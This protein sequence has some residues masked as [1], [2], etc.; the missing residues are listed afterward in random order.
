M[1]CGGCEGIEGVNRVPGT[2]F[3][4]SIFASIALTCFLW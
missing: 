1:K 3:I 4:Q 2:P